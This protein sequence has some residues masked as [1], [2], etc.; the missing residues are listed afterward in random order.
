MAGATALASLPCRAES[1]SAPVI[2]DEPFGYCLNTST[3]RGHSLP[4]AKSVGLIAKAGYRGIE[5]WIRELDEH[6]KTGGSLDDLGKTLTDLGLSVESAIGFFEWVVDDEARRRKALDEARRSMELVRRIG[7]RR[8]AAPPVGATD[9]T[10]IDLN[11]A[12]ERYRALL[13]LGEE[14]GVV[15]QVEVWGFSK[16]LG[17][18]AEA[19]HVSIASGHP[20]ACILPDVFH[21]YKGG[22]GFRGVRQLGKEAI[23]VFHVNDFPADPPRAKISDADRVYPGDGV[24]PLSQLFQDLDANGFRGMLSLELFNKSYYQQPAEVVLETGLKKLRTVVKAA[25]AGKNRGD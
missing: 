11:R 13:E 16:T 22:S 17:T 7:G 4:I 19:A 21:L 3:I 23:H 15:P 20:D 9:R 25:F 12:G 6:V 24:G 1:P 5:P 2:L 10:D 14:M 18:L 8:I